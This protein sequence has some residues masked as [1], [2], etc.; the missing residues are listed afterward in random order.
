MGRFGFCTFHL[1][2]IVEFEYCVWCFMYPCVRF[3]VG[4]VFTLGKGIKKRVYLI[5]FVSKLIFNYN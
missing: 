3:S 2:F 4:F 1:F 5:K